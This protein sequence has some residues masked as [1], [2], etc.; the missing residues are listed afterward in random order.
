MLRLFVVDVYL[1]QPR[2]LQHRRHLNA[3]ATEEQPACREVLDER[4]LTKHG[5]DSSV[6]DLDFENFGC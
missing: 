4:M 5:I 2:A 6:F 3:H 1:Q